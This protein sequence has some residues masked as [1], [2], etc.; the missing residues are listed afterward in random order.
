MSPPAAQ[1][2]L[3]IAPTAKLGARH[4]PLLEGV[5]EID[6]TERPIYA[7]WE[8]TLACDL[9]C[10]HCASRAG[11]A[12]PDELS[13][14][15]CLELVGQMAGMGVKEVTLIGGEA[16][17]HEG[18]TEIIAEVRRHDM[19]CTM[20]TG[21]RG[22]TEER[23]EA[24]ARAG[25]QSIAVSIDGNEEAHD[26]QRGMVG[27]YAAA[28]RALRT[29]RAAGIQVAANTQ[30]NRLSMMHLEHVFDALVAHHCHGWQIQLT[31][32]AGRAA[33]DPALLLQ[34]YD[35][36][37]VFPDLVKIKKK[38]DE[39]RI[40][41]L[42]GNNIGYFGPFD[43]ILRDMFPC[44]HSGN[45]QAG[46]LGLGIEAN[47]GIK[48]CPSL[49]TERWVG[50]SVRD[51]SLKDIWERSEP[52]RFQRDK[53]VEDLWGFCRTCY[54]ADE[55]RGGCT[56][57]SSTLLGKPGNNPYCHHRAVEYHAQGKRERVRRVTA[58]SGQPFD[59]ATWEIIL[60]DMK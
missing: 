35:L 37:E 36:L 11:R 12:R 20:V 9:T 13:V 53:T 27:S 56:W 52:L 43:Y 23:A 2:H 33:D 8:I 1:R 39:A 5:R 15:E 57:M 14:A 55:C 49:P 25:L 47:G 31:V 4:L 17:L 16:Y 38:C 50:G 6:R 54:Y 51:H 40:K 30:V 32:P 46:R 48:G 58:P 44:G 22:M 7:V 21:G 29:C 24:A 42:L 41:L 59:H 60:E 45:C 3:P 10:H 19:Q 34:P 28:L 26:A 18:W